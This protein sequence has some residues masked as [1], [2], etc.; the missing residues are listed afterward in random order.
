MKKTLKLLLFV[1]FLLLLSGCGDWSLQYSETT[2]SGKWEA[3]LARNEKKAFVYAYHWD[4]DLSEEGRVVT[5]PDEVE[6]LRILKLGG[7]YGRGLPMPFTVLTPYP[8][9][10]PEGETAVNEKDPEPCVFTLRLGPELR[11]IENVG[12]PAVFYVER[13]GEYVLMAACFYVEADPANKHFYSE[14][15]ILYRRS[16]GAKVEEID[17]PW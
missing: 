8:A 16:D 9:A 4:G 6:G 5:V 17:Y 15:G 12:W 13:D 11:E 14:D 1:L 2:V 7:Y 3:A 10:L